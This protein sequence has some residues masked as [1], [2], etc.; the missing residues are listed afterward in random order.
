MVILLVLCRCSHAP[1]EI[2]DEV[3]ELPL[4]ARWEL[5]PERQGNWSNIALL[6]RWL[7]LSALHGFPPLPA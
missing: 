2:G 1:N 7:M 5:R 3:S 4:V 6:S